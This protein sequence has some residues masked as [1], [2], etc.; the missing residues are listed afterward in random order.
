MANGGLLVSW[1]FGDNDS[2]HT[3]TPQTGFITDPNSTPN[4]LTAVYENVPT[5][6]SYSVQYAI[7]P[8]ADGWQTVMIGLQ[9]PATP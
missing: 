5:G 2:A 7:G 6:G 1:V 4:Y 8:V 3:F 9:P